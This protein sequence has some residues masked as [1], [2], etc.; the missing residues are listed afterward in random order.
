MTTACEVCDVGV[1]RHGLCDVLLRLDSSN[2]D[3]SIT[4]L[5]DSPADGLGR[6]GFAFSADHGCLPLLLCLF[7]DEACTFSLLLRNLLVLDSLC[8]LLAKCQVGNGH[9]LESDVEL[10]SALQQVR[11]YSVGDGFSLCDELGSIELGDDGLEDFISNGGQHTLIVI[12]A[13]ILVLMSFDLPTFFSF[14]CTHL[15]D[16]RKRADFGT[17]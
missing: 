7:D 13:K 15:V 17:V 10:L 1:I 3:Q 6:L 4:A 8:E 11:S 2:H 5:R 16:F 12:R 14:V 9:I